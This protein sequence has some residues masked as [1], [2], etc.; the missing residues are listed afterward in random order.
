MG[1][2]GRR[3][4]VKEEEKEAEVEK[5]QQE[6]K[7]QKDED[8]EEKEK[9]LRRRR[10]RDRM[11][12]EQQEEDGGGGG[13]RGMMRKRVRRVGFSLPRIL[14]RCQIIFHRLMAF[15]ST[16]LPPPLPDQGT[17]GCSRRYT[18]LR[19]IYE[20]QLCP[21]PHFECV[22][23]LSRVLCLNVLWVNISFIETELLPAKINVHRQQVLKNY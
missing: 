5:E 16:P 19:N 14:L 17:L 13:G 12:K 22:C 4:K 6:E 21:I 23:F 1:R 15:P 2:G 10:R 9:R 18:C 7:E 20:K 8:D 11:E 3:K